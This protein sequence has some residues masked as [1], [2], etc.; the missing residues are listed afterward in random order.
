MSLA[1]TNNPNAVVLADAEEAKDLGIGKDKSAIQYVQ[2]QVVSQGGD[3]EG[4]YVVDKVIIK[5]DS[6]G[7]A[8]QLLP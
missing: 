2:E 7:N 6:Q 1:K 8:T 4:V 3:V 5:V